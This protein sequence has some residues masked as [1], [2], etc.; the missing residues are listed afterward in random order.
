MPELPAVIS[1]VKQ[2][3]RILLLDSLRGIAILGILLVNIRGFGL[4][5]QAIPDPAVNNDTA[6]MNFYAWFINEWLIDGNFRALL[7]MLFGAGMLLFLNRTSREKTKGSELFFRRQFWLFLFG[8][9]NIYLF[10]WFWDILYMYA[11]CGMILFAF[12]RLSATRLFIAAIICLLM[13]DMIDNLELYRQKL[14]IR[15]GETILKTGV[16]TANFNTDQLAAIEEYNRLVKKISLASKQ[17]EAER[18]KQRTNGEFAVLFDLHRQMS[19]TIQSTGFFTFFFWD[20]LL[21]MFLGMAFYKQGMLTGEASSRFYWVLALSGLGVGLL[22]SWLRLRPFMENHFNEYTIIKHVPVR[23]YETARSFRAIGFLGLLMLL[24]KSRCC[25]QLFR[26]L[27]PVG[28]M[29]LTNYL[30]QSIVCGLFFYGIGFGMF[31]KLD[32]IELYYVVMVVWLLQ[33]IF[34]H[35]WLRYF[36]YGPF[37]WAWRSL[38]YWNRQPFRKG[39]LEL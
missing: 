14:V 8:F 3:E 4:P 39:N 13:T 11:I 20:I 9:V 5:Y 26:L 37:E 12:R 32:R 18:S 30:M 22:L 25:G 35:V 31:G 6:G 10:L 1:P 19:V 16:D 29:A 17:K 34:S 7:S 24:Y 15:K 33:I 27:Q 28:Q 2:P 36:L 21:F 38:T 23:F